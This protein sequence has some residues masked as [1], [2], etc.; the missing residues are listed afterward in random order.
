NSW[1]GSSATIFTAATWTAI[2]LEDERC[3][4]RG[5]WL[6]QHGAMISRSALDADVALLTVQRQE[7]AGEGGR[8]TAGHDV[9]R[10]TAKRARSVL[11]LGHSGGHGV[12]FGCR[13]PSRKFDRRKSV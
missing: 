11:L 2:A 7:R 13:F 12:L 8:M 6:L 10:P 5:A 3:N 4:M 1:H 9:Q